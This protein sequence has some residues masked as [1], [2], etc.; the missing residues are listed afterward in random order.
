VAEAV[1]E[2][3]LTITGFAGTSA[4]RVP[5]TA[6]G[7]LA[8]TLLALLVRLPG[9]DREPLWLD[10]GYTLLFSSL[11]LPKLLTVGGAHEHPPLYYLLVHA[12][13]S[14]WPSYL[15]TRLIS[16]L[17]GSLAIPAIFLL[18][19]RFFSAPAGFIAALLLAVSPFHV[20]YSLDGR[21]YELA[22][23]FV[24]LSYLC[25]SMATDGAGWRAW[26][27]YGVVTL[28]ALYT[29]Y[30]TVLVLAPQ[31]L[32]LLRSRRPLIT[33]WIAIALG[34][35]AWIGVVL[36]D[37]ATVAAAYWVPPPTVHDVMTTGLE[38]LG[39]ATPCPS[40]PCTGQV[41]SPISAWPAVPVVIAVAAALLALVLGVRRG[42]FPA[43]VLGLWLF[44]PFAVILALAPVRSL[45]LDRVFLDATYPLFILV[46]V[47]A[48]VLVRRGMAAPAVLVLAALLLANIGTT[49]L[50]FGD[51]R[52]P[53]WRSVARDL[54]AAYRPGQAVMFNPGVLRTLVG[55]YLPSGWHATRERAL[56][57]RSYI[58]V[59]GWQRYYPQA[60][61]T[62]KAD[63]ARL[64]AL[65]RD[66]QL[67]D[68]TRDS[69]LT[70]LVTYDYPGVSDTRRWFTTHGFQPLVSEIYFGDTR[71]E[72]WGRAGPSS[73][74]TP[75]EP[76]TF[77]RSWR[78]KGDVAVNAA[79]AT[80]N[81]RSSLTRRFRVHPGEAY[82]FD[83]GYQAIPPA[84]PTV[85]VSVY[86]S[87]GDRLGTYPRTRYYD[88]PATGVWLR[89]PFGLVAPP[90]AYRAV[91]TV[92]NRWGETRW[93]AVGIYGDGTP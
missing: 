44:L 56:W 73:L 13:M 17:A 47:A 84:G 66:R 24:L 67:A 48:V 91:L 16:T 19:R 22:G 83:V 89:Q 60:S 64:E 2:R 14:I 23:L 8:L 28:A 43:V 10:E 93:R 34:Y 87:D 51:P 90:G 4:R 49:S 63:R 86:N 46:G 88:L 75:V 3:A 27:A 33:T 74:G 18:A 38:F 58:D 1:T 92:R 78:A 21:A 9:L 76:P 36:R 72:L 25:L 45:Y 41:F 30:M 31:A 29:E 35:A 11:P 26:A 80:E 7:L 50:L 32:Y 79:T 81:G 71:L 53:D 77:D 65:L 54:R 40:P 20:W 39:L 52:N 59:P 82:S 68:V 5:L 15:V 12:G 6:L 57:T 55:S 85:S 70:W 37:T 42:D 62:G 61:R 69:R